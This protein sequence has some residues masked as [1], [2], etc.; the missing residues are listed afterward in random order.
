MVHPTQYRETFKET[1]RCT[2]RKGGIERKREGSVCGIII[3]SEESCHSLWVA[4]EY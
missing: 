1:Q 4:F 2:D 3:K